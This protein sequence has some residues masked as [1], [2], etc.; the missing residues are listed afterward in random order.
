M[1]GR[2]HLWEWI[3]WVLTNY[4]IS[5]GLRRFDRFKF[6]IEEKMVEILDIVQGGRSAKIYTEPYP[7][8]CAMLDL[9]CR[10]YTIVYAKFSSG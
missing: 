2:S 9:M 10:G 5:S 4:A 8:L 6:N 1:H 3:S 7:M